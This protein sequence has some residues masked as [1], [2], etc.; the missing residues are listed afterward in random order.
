MTGEPRGLIN[1]EPGEPC[2]LV[3]NALCD[4]FSIGLEGETEFFLRGEVVGGAF[5]FAGL[6][7]LPG[8]YASGVALVDFPKGAPPP[9]WLVTPLADGE[10]H[11]LISRRSGETL[12]AYRVEAGV[13][14]VVTSLY[15]ET[16]ACVA[17]AS[18]DGFTVLR[19]P[20]RLG[21]SGILIA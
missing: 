5:A 10:G 15:D 4:R 2:F 19:G 21:S 8:A 11:A 1:V 14:R 18:E 3:G 6:L 7:F 17:A 16:G 12:F 13:C 20:A 9:G